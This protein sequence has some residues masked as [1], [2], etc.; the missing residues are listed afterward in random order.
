VTTADDDAAAAGAP[1]SSASPPANAEAV[2]RTAQESSDATAVWGVVLGAAG[3]VLGIA[4]LGLVLAGR[5]TSATG[6]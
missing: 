1:A 3:F 5:R 6:K 2:S 4:A